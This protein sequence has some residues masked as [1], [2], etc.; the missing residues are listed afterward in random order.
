M[1][2]IE[3]ARSNR[4]CD[5]LTRRSFLRVGSLGLAGLSLADLLASRAHA[6]KADFVRDKSVVFLYLAGGPS[7]IE[8][9]D[10]KMDA[11]SE[12]RSMTGECQTRLPG[13][14]FGG[15]FPKLSA[16]VHVEIE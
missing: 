13:I 11:P 2:T 5:G 9:F 15:T 1:F 14:T 12:V 4:C 7:Q 16:M 6:G 10:P 8:T 3:T